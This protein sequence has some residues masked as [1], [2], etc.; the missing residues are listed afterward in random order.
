MAR[1]WC[2]PV[3]TLAMAMAAFGAVQA[4]G[5]TPALAQSKTLTISWWG[6]NG[7]KLEEIILKPFRAQCGCELVLL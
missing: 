2:R 6:F 7:E 5:F 3:A 4:V 1:R